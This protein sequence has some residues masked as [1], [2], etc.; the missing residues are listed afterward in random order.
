M[1]VQVKICGIKTRSAL[2]AA[3]AAGADMFGLVF[4]DRSPRHVDLATA[5]ELAKLGRGRL[6]SVALLVD[7]TDDELSQVLRHVEPDMIQLHGSE[8]PARVADVK[9][10]A[11]RP[12]IKA[13]KVASADDVH[14]A[15]AYDAAALILYD[16]KPSASTDLPGGNGQSFD[17]GLLGH[18]EPRG[19]FMLSGGLNAANVARAIGETGA[20]WVDVSSGV[21]TAPGVKDAGLITR[22]IAAARSAEAPA[23][24]P[25]RERMT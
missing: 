1:V 16:A 6:T 13:I 11:G 14:G 3:H 9:A 8:T 2:E 4:F 24:K 18:V 10:L 21:E 22:F 19:S 12:I 17:W 7:P 15:R 25:E 20:R 5:S 23:A